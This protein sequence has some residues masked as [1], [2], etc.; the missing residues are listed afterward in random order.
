[1][2][3][4]DDLDYQILKVL[5]KDGSKTN[6]ELSRMMGTSVNTIRN[7]IQR[8]QEIGVLQIRGIT[9]PQLL[10]F[11]IHVVMGVDVSYPHLAAVGEGFAKMKSVRYVAYAG[12]A[13]DLV[14]M[15][16]FINMDHFFKWMT[17]QV[18]TL[19][20]ITSI[21]TMFVAKEVKRNYDYVGQLEEIKQSEFLGEF[22]KEG[23]NDH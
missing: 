18:S 4:L 22:K 19:E 7:R 3:Y 17:E 12:G 23:N 10:G 8:M 13:H 1:M 2:L 11:D 16:F 5:M 9:N 21:K 15:A 14:V 6:V 20:G